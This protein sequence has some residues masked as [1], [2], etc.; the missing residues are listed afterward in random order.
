LLGIGLL[1]PRDHA[2]RTC[3]AAK[4]PLADAVGMKPMLSFFARNTA[5]VPPGSTD[6]PH[7]QT[8][9]RVAR[10]FQFS[11]LLPLQLQLHSQ[12]RQEHVAQVPSQ[13]SGLSCVR[14]M[15]ACALASG[16]SHT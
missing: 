2:N 11:F 15:F 1:C 6:I 8:P 12:P 14:C 7:Q 3:K 4:K 16:Y 13:V 9:T 10:D 5:Q